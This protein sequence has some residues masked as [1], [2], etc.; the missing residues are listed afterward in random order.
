MIFLSCANVIFDHFLQ[1][2][3]EEYPY[4]KSNLLLLQ[5]KIPDYISPIKMKYGKQ[6]RTSEV[7]QE[8]PEFRIF[9]TAQTPNP[10]VHLLSNGNYHVMINNAGSGFS[11]FKD[12]ALTKW[13]E[14]ICQDNFGFY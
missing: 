2:L 12:I 6:K 1:D 3:F 7:T 11:Q 5:E 14:D 13:R 9:T 4:F 8:K 10:E